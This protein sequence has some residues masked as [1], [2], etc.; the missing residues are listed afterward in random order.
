MCLYYLAQQVNERIVSDFQSK[1]DQNT[2]QSGDNSA[3]G[4]LAADRARILALMLGAVAFDGWSNLT[5]ERVG[6]EAGI[7][8]DRLALLFPDGVT[9]VLRFWQME[10]DAAHISQIAKI[11]DF[12]AQKVRDKV[13]SAV[14]SRLALYAPHKEA[15]RRQAAYLALPQNAQLGA[16]LCWQAADHIWRV[17]GD[18]STDFNYYSKRTIL[19]GVWTSTFARWLGDDSDDCAATE[20]FLRARIENVMQ[21]EKLK[22]RVPDPQPHIAALISLAAKLRYGADKASAKDS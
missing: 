5:L 12:G 8:R 13:A 20:A 10:I 22:R 11:E 18:T 9:D 1:P 14:R 19:A 2:D 7:G 17:L 15:A 6:A 21:F 16:R 3:S 4:A